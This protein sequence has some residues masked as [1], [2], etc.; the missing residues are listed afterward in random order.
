MVRECPLTHRSPFNTG[1]LYIQP[2]A[3]CQNRAFLAYD[4]R[5][6]KGIGIYVAASKLWVT[7]DPKANECLK[8]SLEKA[9]CEVW[10]HGHKDSG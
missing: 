6:H 2:G 7:T 4:G 9:F 1:G 3:E 8:W 10:N 5:I